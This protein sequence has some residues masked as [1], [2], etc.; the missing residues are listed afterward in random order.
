MSS[1]EL[2]WLWERREV[3]YGWVLFTGVSKLSTE[4]FYLVT[5]NEIEII[6]EH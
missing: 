6:S 1:M 2:D 3:P 4:A 5:R